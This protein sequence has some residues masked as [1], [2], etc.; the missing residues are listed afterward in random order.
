M[1]YSWPRKYRSL[2]KN[3]FQNATAAII[4]YDITL[5]SSFEEIKKFW[6]NLVINSCPQG[7]N[8]FLSF[9]NH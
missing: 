5:K 1:G 6:Y 4:V 8:K 9:F 2:A 3:F 7:I